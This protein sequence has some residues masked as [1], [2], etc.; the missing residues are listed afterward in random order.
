MNSIQI[1][2]DQISDIGIDVNLDPRLLICSI[3]FCLNIDARECMNKKCQ[4][5]FCGSCAN[6]NTKKH[7]KSSQEKNIC[8][9]CR[10]E[11]DFT[12]ASDKLMDIIKNIL[13]FCN[14]LQCNKKFTL[15]EIIHHLKNPS[16]PN[17][18]FKCK[19]NLFL[20]VP[21]TKC[22]ICL[23]NF[24]TDKFEYSNKNKTSNHT[25]CKN[26]K[27]CFNCKMSVCRDCSKFS[28]NNNKGEILCG[29]CSIDCFFCKSDE[30]HKSQEANF[31]CNL[32]N[33]PLCKNCSFYCDECQ[34]F[35]C[36]DSKCYKDKSSNCK[37]CSEI[38]LNYFYNKCAHKIYVDCKSC[39]NK[40]FDCNSLASY[41]CKI[42][43]NFICIKDCSTR[44]KICKDIL[45]KSCLK[46]CSICKY[47]CCSSCLTKCDDCSSNLYSCNNCNID[48]IRKCNNNECNKKL[49]I[50]CWHVCNK[51]NIIF[52]KEHSINCINCEDQ[53]CPDHFHNCETCNKSSE[54]KKFKRLCSK[55]TF[56]CSFCESVSNA[57]CSKEKHKDNLVKQLNCGHNVCKNCLKGCG[58]CG[59]VVVSCPKCIVNYYFHYCK[60]CEFYLC[61]TCAKFCNSC[62]DISCSSL[63]KCHNCKI[64]ISDCLN[65]HNLKKTTCKVCGYKLKNC[66]NCTKIY[67]CSLNCYKEYS[68]REQTCKCEIF[69]CTEHIEKSLEENIHDIEEKRN[70]VINKSDLPLYNP[71][72]VTHMSNKVKIGC[73]QACC[74]IY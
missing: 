39:Y 69:S 49:C 38:P 23:N 44:C 46:S 35:I 7:S 1:G 43:N 13:F 47:I 73:N 16:K 4:K 10:L 72:S 5:L 45:C 40:C 74:S 51:C 12:K 63:H 17:L 50:N 61:A 65:C 8:P 57:L 33:K 58:K 42:C 6:I 28:T 21:L 24:C 27:R 19:N 52:C 22:G 2:I 55:C 70:K 60:L 34:N 53:S 20:K 9:F 41:S 67:I 14:E 48:T 15:E 32:C 59:N 18:C 3:C 30:S 31:V 68:G 66:H 62:E 56:Q 36:L 37:E 29:I 54:D 71:K 64:A 26:I 25:T 11:I